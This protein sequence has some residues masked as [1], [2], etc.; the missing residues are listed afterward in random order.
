SEDPVRDDDGTVL[1]EVCS[2]VDMAEGPAGLEDEPLLPPS[3]DERSFT[4]DPG[5]GRTKV[6]FARAEA[7]APTREMK[8]A[9]VCEVDPG[10]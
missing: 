1:V 2:D 5:S 10:D 7:E 3:A 8:D 9:E 4:I 6:S